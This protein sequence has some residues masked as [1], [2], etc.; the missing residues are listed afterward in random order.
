VVE[1]LRRVGAGVCLAEP[2]Q[3][4]WLRG[5]KKRAKSDRADAG[6]LRELL[7]V[8]RVPGSWIVAARATARPGV[9]TGRDSPR[10]RPRP[11]AERQLKSAMVAFSNT[12]SGSVA[13]AR[14]S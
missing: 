8:G 10:P 14:G 1:E 4:G 11:P 5:A 9:Q 13:D 6:H 3:T 7:M 2:A 12:D